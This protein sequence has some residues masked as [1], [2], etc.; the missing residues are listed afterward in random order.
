MSRR[1]FQDAFCAFPL[2][3]VNPVAYYGILGPLEFVWHGLRWLHPTL[4]LQLRWRIPCEPQEM[5]F[6]RVG[7]F[8]ET[9]SEF[10][11]ECEA[12]FAEPLI[13]L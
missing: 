10:E 5:L 2:R 7:L 6:T 8:A 11:T 3:I 1:I 4:V 13:V 12:E 9:V